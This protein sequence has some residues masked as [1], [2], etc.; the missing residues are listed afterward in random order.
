MKDIEVRFFP[1]IF[2]WEESLKN[3]EL[4][5]NRFHVVGLF[6]A[7]DGHY[8]D[9]VFSSIIQQIVDSASVKIKTIYFDIEEEYS[10]EDDAEEDESD[11]Q[12]D[13]IVVMEAYIIMEETF[14]CTRRKEVVGK[15]REEVTEVLSGYLID[16]GKPESMYYC[17]YVEVKREEC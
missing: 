14:P 16:N 10:F 1:P 8:A 3:A 13:E 2:D 11:A 4:E 12:Y 5:S 9:N 15:L 6:F 7:F 17:D